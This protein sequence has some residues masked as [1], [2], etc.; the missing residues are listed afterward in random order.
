MY[1]YIS[2]IKTY[3]VERVSQLAAARNL[4]LAG[5]EDAFTDGKSNPLSID[6]LATNLTYT[7]PWNNIWE[8]GSGKHAYQLANAG[9][10]VIFQCFIKNISHVCWLLQ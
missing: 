5:W 4:N 2:G 10:K 8:W 1:L 7:Y 9:Y 3:F 6:K